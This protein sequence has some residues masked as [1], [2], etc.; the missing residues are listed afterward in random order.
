MIDF[1]KLEYKP[2][3]FLSKVFRLIE[4]EEDLL[5]FKAVE[6]QFSLLNEDY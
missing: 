2:S 3:P 6:L 4:A 1:E 5:T